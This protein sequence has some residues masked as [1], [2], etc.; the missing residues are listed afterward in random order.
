MI[1]SLRLIAFARRRDF[2]ERLHGR[3]DPVL[4]ALERVAERVGDEQAELGDLGRGQELALGRGQLHDLGDQ[5]ELRHGERPELQLEADEPVGRRQDGAR[6][7]AGALLAA[8]G[9]GD[10]PEHAEQERARADGGVGHGH[11]RRGEP[12]RAVEAALEHV[13]DQAHHLADDL[14]RRVVRAGLL[15]EVVVVD[16]QEVL[17]EVEPGLGAVPQRVGVEQLGVARLGVLLDDPAPLHDAQHARQR[18]DG[19]VERGAVERLVGEQLERRADERV[20]GAELAR[21]AVEPGVER[22]VARAISSPNVTVCA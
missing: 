18:A 8:H 1:G 11:V 22:D 2:R 19:G 21:D 14:G 20:P 16:R 6:H 3:R 5:A 12:E 13:V 4:L 17:V 15:A 7:G 10:A 9:V